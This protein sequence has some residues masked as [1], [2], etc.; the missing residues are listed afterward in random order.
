[1]DTRDGK[2]LMRTKASI[3]YTRLYMMEYIISI[4]ESVNIF[5][6]QRRFFLVV[7]NYVFN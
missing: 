2:E 1:M 4:R 3:E 5:K 6:F 7:G